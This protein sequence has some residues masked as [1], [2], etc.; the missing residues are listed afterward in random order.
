MSGFY[1]SLH[2]LAQ[3]FIWGVRMK[4]QSLQSSSQAAQA[5]QAEAMKSASAPSLASAGKEALARCS[6]GDATSALLDCPFV[7]GRS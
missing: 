7:L 1:A 5:A 6:L 2:R 3:V 4:N